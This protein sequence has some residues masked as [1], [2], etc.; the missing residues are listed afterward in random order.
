[1]READW[2]N[3]E[4]WPQC[5][6]ET[7]LTE[8]RNASGHEIAH[9]PIHGTHRHLEFPRDGRGSRRAAPPQDF[10]DLKETIG[11]AHDADIML[12]VGLQ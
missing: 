6:A 7:G 3:I 12:S 9:V 11:P 10:N 8:D 1:L 4:S 5:I 2:R